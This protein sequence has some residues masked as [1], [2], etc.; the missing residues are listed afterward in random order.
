VQVVPFFK[1]YALYVKNYQTAIDIMRDLSTQST[2]NLTSP[3]QLVYTWITELEETARPVLNG[4]M[5]NDLLIMP[6]Q[7]VP[8]YVMLLE[9]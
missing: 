4:L 3:H 8:R 7:R 2:R 6:V 5:L 9:V 1:E